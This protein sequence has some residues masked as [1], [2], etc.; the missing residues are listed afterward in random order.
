MPG[1]LDD[2]EPGVGDLAGKCPLPGRAARSH[3][4]P[5]ASTSVGAP[6]LQSRS[7]ISNDSSC[8]SRSAITLWPVSQIRSTTKSTSGP[9]SGLLPK[10]RWK[11]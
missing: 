10:S 9:G 4:E 1:V 2:R 7:E 6:M 3:R 5:P 11:N 8:A